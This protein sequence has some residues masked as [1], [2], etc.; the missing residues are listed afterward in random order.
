MDCV[1]LERD[2]NVGLETSSCIDNKENAMFLL[3]VDWR[4]WPWT[5]WP[6]KYDQ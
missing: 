1:D 4:M 2:E 5:R 6:E 3:D